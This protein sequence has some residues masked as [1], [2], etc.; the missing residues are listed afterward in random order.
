MEGAAASFIHSLYNVYRYFVRT[1]QFLLKWK[2]AKVILVFK[3][4]SQLKVENYR[5]ISLLKSG[6]KLFEMIIFKQLL[7]ID[8]PYVGTTTRFQNR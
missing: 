8:T 1:S 4:G 2:E 3:K 7:D 5:P 6:S